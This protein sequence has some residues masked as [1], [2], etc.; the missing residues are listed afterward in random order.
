M[1]DTM[2]ALQVKIVH[3]ETCQLL[4]VGYCV[5]ATLETELDDGTKATIK[6][7]DSYTIP[8]GHNARVVGD[9]AWVG[10]E[11]VSADEYAAPTS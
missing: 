5:S 10:I 6:P 8:P 2:N 1:S 3:T 11:F 9:E 7:G 4:Y